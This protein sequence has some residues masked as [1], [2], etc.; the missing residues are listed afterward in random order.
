MNFASP[1]PAPRPASECN[2]LSCA[3]RAADDGKFWMSYDDF[4]RIW[5]SVYVSAMSMPTERC[6]HSQ[7]VPDA[8]KETCRRRVSEAVRPTAETETAKPPTAETETARNPT[9]SSA[10]DDAVKDIMRDKLGDAEY[11]ADFADEA[12]QQILADMKAEVAKHVTGEGGWKTATYVE[13]LSP[14]SGYVRRSFKR[15]IA[16][17]C[18][19]GVTYT[20]SKGVI[21]YAYIVAFQRK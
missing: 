13:V 17:D 15:A 2:S 12:A 19:K 21:A 11:S 8:V 10:L 6:K 20:N 16:S 14:S 3:L 5:T 4:K 18:A 1:C 9:D 7:P